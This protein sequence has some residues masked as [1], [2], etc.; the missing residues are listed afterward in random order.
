MVRRVGGW[1]AVEGAYTEGEEADVRAADRGTSS[2]G[3]SSTVN[4]GLDR[5]TGRDDPVIPVGLITLIP[6]A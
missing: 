2:S 1:L 6:L 3:S 4:A 5:P